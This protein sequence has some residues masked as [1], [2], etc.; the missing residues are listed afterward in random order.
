MGW[1]DDGY[2]SWVKHVPAHHDPPDELSSPTGIAN[3]NLVIRILESE[4][5][6]NDVVELLGQFLTEVARYNTWFANEVDGKV[7]Q[8]THAAVYTTYRDV[9]SKVYE[10]WKQYEI[11]CSTAPPSDDAD[12]EMEPEYYGL[13]ATLRSVVEELSTTRKIL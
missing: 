8:E 9:T 10:A 4:L 6:G 3:L 5:V 12:D 11:V 13:G 1:P 7:S 2:W